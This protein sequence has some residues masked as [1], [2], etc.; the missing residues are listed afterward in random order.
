MSRDVVGGLHLQRMSPDDLPEVL[1]IEY[2]VYPFPWTHGNFLDSIK[3]GYESWILRD[4]SDQNRLLAY[5]LV[6]Q[7][8]DESH[9]L[10]ITVHPEY[11]GRGFGRYLLDKVTALA[12]ASGMHAVLLEVR[13]SNIRALR[14]YL[15][16]GFSRIG[17]RRNYYPAPDNQREDAIVMRLPL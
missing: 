4:T 3:S 2:A 6:M 13:P 15:R 11:N 10:N 5:F 8:V 9:L 14:I 7:A 1:E 17:V 16:Y 12:R